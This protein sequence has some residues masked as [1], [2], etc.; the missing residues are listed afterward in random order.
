MQL[1][2]ALLDSTY[3]T[4]VQIKTNSCQVAYGCVTCLTLAATTAKQKRSVPG[5]R[6][7]SF[8]DECEL[9]TLSATPDEPYTLG[10]HTS[11]NTALAASVY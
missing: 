9:F 5:G 4:R 7:D 6:H 1:Q 11:S 8:A 3:E 10:H 2:T